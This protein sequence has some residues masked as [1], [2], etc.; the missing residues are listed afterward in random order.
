MLNRNSPISERERINSTLNEYNVKTEDEFYSVVDS[1]WHKTK[2]MR[3]GREISLLNC[4][5]DNGDPV[6]VEH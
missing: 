5:F 1:T 6:C 2:C 3:C 4:H